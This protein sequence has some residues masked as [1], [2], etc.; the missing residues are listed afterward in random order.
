MQAAEGTSGTRNT[1]SWTGG[2]LARWEVINETVVHDGRRKGKGEAADDGPLGRCG[3]A[4]LG[5]PATAIPARLWQKQGQDAARMP[6]PLPAVPDRQPDAVRFDEVS[7]AASGTSRVD[8]R[9][10]VDDAIARI[11]AGCV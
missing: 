6:A 10:T 4:S 9:E 2:V 7:R 8:A 3:W 1:G 5:R 11:A